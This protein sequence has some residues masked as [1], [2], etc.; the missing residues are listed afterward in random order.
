MVETL[1]PL[2]SCSLNQLKHL[3]VTHS[4]TLLHLSAFL[5]SSL[6]FF[7]AETVLE[8][9]SGKWCHCWLPGSGYHVNQCWRGRPR[10]VSVTARD[11]YGAISHLWNSPR[12]DKRVGM[13]PSLCI[14]LLHSVRGQVR[15]DQAKS[16]WQDCP[17]ISLC[18]IIRAVIQ[19]F[20]Q[21]PKDITIDLF[22]RNSYLEDFYL[23][24]WQKWGC[25]YFMYGFLLQLMVLF[26]LL[27]DWRFLYHVVFTSY[28]PHTG[29]DSNN[30]N[31][32]DHMAICNLKSHTFKNEHFLIKKPS[33][34]NFKSYLSVME[35]T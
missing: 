17:L 25:C 35:I 34:A 21:S 26:S 18:H 29:L 2:I 32:D 16:M 7:V 9:N 6:W 15:V 23:T 14:V 30:N 13:C 22:P 12:D 19:I 20:L 31:Q 4:S 10:P 5:S 33:N 24:A 1:S 11:R 28:G 3:G 27:I 8:G